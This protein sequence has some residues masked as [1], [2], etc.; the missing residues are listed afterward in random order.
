[1][2][3]PLSTARS[4]LSQHGD[5]LVLLW[6]IAGSAC[7]A[8]P[9]ALMPVLLHSASSCGELSPRPGE[10]VSGKVGNDTF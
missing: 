4:S 6:I 5:E 7:C 1:M 10:V 8:P 9:G 2:E 3:T